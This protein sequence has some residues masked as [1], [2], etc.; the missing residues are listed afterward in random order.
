MGYAK[1]I[2][3][4]FA[5][6]IINAVISFVVSVIT[7]RALGPEG[8]G[9]IAYL[10]LIFGLIASYGHFGINNAT[11]YFQK[12]TTYSEE[13][14]FNN[15]I[16]YLIIN[17]FIISIIIFTLKYFGVIL[18]DYDL[19]FV[20][21]GLLFVFF[22]Y[23]LT[24][25]TGFYIGNER[26]VKLNQYY[27]TSLIIRLVL[28]TLLFIFKRINVKLIFSAY[29]ISFF[30]YSYFLLRNIGIRYRFKLNADLLKKEF[31]YGLIIY[32]SALFVFLNY[33]VDQFMIKNMLGIGEL[34]IYSI[35]VSFAELI[36]LIPDSVSTALLGKLYNIDNFSPKRNFLTSMTIKY[37]FYI[38]VA[39]IT[40]GSFLTPLIPL[41]FGQDFQRASMVTIILFSGIIFASIAKVAISYFFSQ[42]RPKVHLVI[43]FLVVVLNIIFNFLLIPVWGIN[44][45]A[46]ASSISYFF[47]GVTYI[48]WFVFKEKFSFKDFFVFTEVDKK[49]F[50]SILK[51]NKK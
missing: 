14:V 19:S 26:I 38:C 15:N 45:A 31:Q 40:I 7:A 17:F 27:I 39:L 48:I 8:K 51:R 22:S 36:L 21:L 50:Y 20:I 10:L 30:L 5:A 4:N 13:E 32:F 37:T 6:Q 43:S 18:S 24:S 12:R 42:G 49:L 11:T 28:I 41:I 3:S 46:I 9:S 34:G 29:V 33:R 16:S 23:L 2:F 25:A 35:G 44:G 1:N 47:Y